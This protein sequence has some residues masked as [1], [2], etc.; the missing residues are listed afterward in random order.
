MDKSRGGG[1]PPT[2]TP[3]MWVYGEYSLDGTNPAIKLSEKLLLTDEI[4][5]REM[6][7]RLQKT[8]TKSPENTI[9]PTEIDAT[10]KGAKIVVGSTNA[11][12]WHG[13]TYTRV[14]KKTKTDRK[15][16]TSILPFRIRLNGVLYERDVVKAR[17]RPKRP[18]P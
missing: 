6:P 8:Y 18:G 9:V 2:P 5:L 14:K 7:K 13:V 15:G 1:Y 4:V 10:L 12:Q 11:I 17:P 16:D 3:T